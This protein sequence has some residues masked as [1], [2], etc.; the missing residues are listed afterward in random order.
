MP[1]NN[2]NSSNAATIQGPGPTGNEGYPVSTAPAPGAGP[3]NV[4]V[5]AGGGGAVTIADGADINQGATTDP[6]N[7]TGAAGT[8]SGKLRGLLTIL[9]NVWDSVNGWIK[10]SIQNATLAVTQSGAWSI[11]VNN[12]PATQPVSGT[13]TVNQGT[14]PWVVGDGGGSLSVDDGGGSLTVDGT[15]TANQ[16][17]PPWQNVGTHAFSSASFTRPAN[18]TAYGVGDVV[19]N[20]T[21]VPVV[22]TF[23]NCARANG[24]TGRLVACRV[25][26]SANQATKFAGE[27]WLF[28]TTVTPDNDNATFTPT[29]AELETLVG[30]FELN[31]T[32]TEEIHYFNQAATI[33]AGAAGNFVYLIQNAIGHLFQ[34]QGG[35]RDLYG[36]LVA[37]VAY[38]PV[39]SEVFSFRLQISYD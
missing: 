23:A 38:T 16:G 7:T 33:A 25:V 14:S 37:R 8:M 24:G 10:V 29:E 22:L 3:W 20:S 6:A 19:N 1:A 9:T 15:V 27:L 32:P 13:V 36:V 18:T 2:P 31:L 28:D 34:C 11:A 35:S 4:S 26:D 30:V 39:S 17:T 5:V 12:F 21:T